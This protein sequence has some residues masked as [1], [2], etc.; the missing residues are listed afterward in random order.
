MTSIK[1]FITN[2]GRYNEGCLI[3]EWVD[4]PI[5][6]DDLKEVFNRIGISD[7][8]AENGIIYDEYFITDYESPFKF[9]EYTP[10]NEI[11]EVA[12]RY[13]ELDDDQ[14][15][16]LDVLLEEHTDDIEEAFNIVENYDYIIWN[17]CQ[18]MSDVAYQY[19]SDSGMLDND[20]ILSRYFDY[21]SYGRDMELE[22]C[23]YQI[24][25]DTYLEVINF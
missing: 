5:D 20:S 3:G 22:G 14:K 8:P 19:L 21:K 13:D 24:D 17:N 1:G 11:N 23:F 15:E 12:A 25:S 6:E 10:I 9:G 18:D 7:Q 16:V 4:F 2:L